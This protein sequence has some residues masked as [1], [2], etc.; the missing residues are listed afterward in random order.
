MVFWRLS[1]FYLFYFASLGA[2]LP[3][4]SLYLAGVGFDA[5]AIGQL[6]AMMM[7]AKIVSPNLW[8]WI[9][10]RSRQRMRIVRLGSLA[11]LV[12]FAGVFL[13]NGFWWMAAVMMVFSFF[14]NASLPQV[15]VTTLNHL[16]AHTHRYSAIRLWGSIGFIAAAAALGA[17][18]DRFGM[19]MLPVVLLGLFGAIWLSSLSVP[20]REV[21]PPPRDHRRLREVLRHPQVATLLGV[22][23]LMQAGHG[24]YYTFYSIYLQ[25]QGY[26]R[27][28]IGQ[29]WALGVI[30]EIGVFLVMHRLVPRWG[31]RNLL[32]G[33]LALAALRWALIG[34]FVGEV[35]VLIAAQ[36]MHA[37]SFGIYHASAIELIHRH[38]RGRHQGRGQALYSSLS[39]GAGGA[40]GALYSGYL[41]DLGGGPLAFGA[42]AGVSVLAWLLAWRGLRLEA[43]KC[44]NLP[45]I[46]VP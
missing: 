21:A 34:G 10:D 5:A 7:M 42:A 43:G 8:G 15:E 40:A 9:A 18:L 2:M 31:L 26:S 6:T 12:S 23:F 44:G 19:A 13:G 29:L 11:A 4:W 16:G 20:E 39:F 38:F 33:S 25:G 27:G 1:G 41:W 3:Y 32:L 22:C 17:L 46:D 14:W 24:P 37:A 36:L 35:A 28:A 30:A 45:E